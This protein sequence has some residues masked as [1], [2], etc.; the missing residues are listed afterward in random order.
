MQGTSDRRKTLT[1]HGVL[2]SD[3]RL[4]MTTF[5]VRDLVSVDGRMLVQEKKELQ[6][7]HIYRTLEMERPRSQRRLRKFSTVRAQSLRSRTW[8]IGKPSRATRPTLAKLPAKCFDAES[9]LRIAGM[10]GSD[11]IRKRDRRPRLHWNGSRRKNVIATRVENLF[12]RGR[13]PQLMAAEERT[14]FSRYSD[15]CWSESSF[16]LSLLD[17]PRTQKPCWPSLSSWI[18]MVNG[19]LGNSG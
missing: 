8:S 18:A 10:D 12:A 3:D 13:L 4:P 1:V 17:S 14:G 7:Y 16:A 2:S 15:N 5:D 6:V 19:C 11:A 9:T